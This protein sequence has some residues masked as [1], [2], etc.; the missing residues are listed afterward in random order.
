VWWAREPP[1]L[2]DPA[3]LLGAALQSE[4]GAAALALAVFDVWHTPLAPRM[5]GTMSAQH[6]IKYKDRA[7]TYR[8]ASIWSD[9]PKPGSRWAIPLH[10]PRSAKNLVL[11][12]HSPRAGN[13]EIIDP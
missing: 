13:W 3:E 9:G 2:G 12:K 7:G 11:V 6:I 1:V 8:E 4:D 10:L 5:G